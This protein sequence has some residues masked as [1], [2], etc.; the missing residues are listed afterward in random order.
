MQLKSIFSLCA[1]LVA[2]SFV[3]TQND[4]VPTPMRPF[5]LY[6]S[7]LSAGVGGNYSGGFLYAFKGDLPS[8]VSVARDTASAPSYFDIGAYLEL[9]SPHSRVNFSM[10]I[11][12]SQLKIVL[13]NKNTD[14]R[15][16]LTIKQVQIP[17][18]MRYVF[19][20]KY[21]KA[22]P[23]LMLGG[24]YNLPLSF[25]NGSFP[26]N[27]KAMKPTYSLHVGGGVQLNFR[28][29]KKVEYNIKLDPKDPN[30][31]T[32]PAVL[33]RSWI[34]FKA[35]YTPVNLIDNTQNSQI[36]QNGSNLDFDLHDL[37]FCIGAA[38]FFGSKKK[39][40]L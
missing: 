34:F 14:I 33:G 5:T 23:M 11:G 17:F 7:R 15:D 10:G 29:S 9:Y 30:A 19:G 12:Y 2:P 40:S 8:N 26:K 27:K 18:N 3:F 32:I 4:V 37:K 31:A 13:E 6:Q 21:A 36:F 20:Q 22:N 25:A 16:E 38:A 35:S 39:H 1:I 28:G 24:C